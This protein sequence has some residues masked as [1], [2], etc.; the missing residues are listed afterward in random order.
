MRD[1]GRLKLLAI[2]K[3]EVFQTSAISL[4]EPIISPSSI[5]I[6][7]ALNG[8]LSERHVF[9]VLWIFCHL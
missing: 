1:S 7:F 8:V 6:I 5:N 4:S 2:L 3:K 9:T